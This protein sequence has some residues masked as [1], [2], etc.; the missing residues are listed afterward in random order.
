MKAEF[1]AQLG[2]E[3]V[4]YIDKLPYSYLA[5]F[6]DGRKIPA[7]SLQEYRDAGYTI[8]PRRTA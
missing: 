8:E 7:S 5:T 4:A 3:I 6:K 1:T 2:G